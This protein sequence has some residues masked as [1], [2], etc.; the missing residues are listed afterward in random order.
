MKVAGIEFPNKCTEDCLLKN[1]LRQFGQNSICTRC[2][3][4]S[5]CGKCRLIEPEEYRHDWAKE[6]K[7]FFD[8]KYEYIPMLL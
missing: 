3:V 5:C 8:S 2:P 6:W 7:K 1:D 4:F